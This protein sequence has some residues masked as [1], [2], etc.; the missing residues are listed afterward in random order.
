MDRGGGY[1]NIRLAFYPV[2]SQLGL[3]V[4]QGRSK[5]HLG[6]RKWSSRYTRD[7]RSTFWNPRFNSRRKERRLSWVAV[8]H[9]EASS[10]ISSLRAHPWGLWNCQERAHHLHKLQFQELLLQVS[11]CSCSD[12]LSCLTIKLFDTWRMGATCCGKAH[13]AS[14]TEID[15]IDLKTPT[16]RSSSPKEGDLYEKIDKCTWHC[17]AQFLNQ[18]TQMLLRLLKSLGSTLLTTL[19]GQPVVLSGLTS[20]Q[21]VRCIKARWLLKSDRATVNKCSLM[22][23]FTRVTGKTIST[24]AMADSSI[25]TAIATRDN[26]RTIKLMALESTTQ[27]MGL[28]MR[29]TGWIKPFTVKE[30]STTRMVPSTRGHLGM[31]QKVGMEGSIGQINA[32]TKGSFKTI[33]FMARVPMCLLTLGILE[34]GSRTM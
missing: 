7:S 23:A 33:C 25:Q 1:S 29:E 22:A 9:Q 4:Q 13:T 3:H 34:S 30:K 2:V 14:I 28:A 16:A 31:E 24:M 20:L 12:R 32:P 18:Q 15:G 10:K 21:M 11:E 27:R 26:L 5:T 6:H 17:Y 19:I 8:T